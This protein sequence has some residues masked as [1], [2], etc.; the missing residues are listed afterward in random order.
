MCKIQNLITWKTNSD[1][2]SKEFLQ[3]VGLF[4]LSAAS[5]R[6]EQEALLL[7]C[8]RFHLLPPLPPN[9]FLRK[10][11]KNVVM[12]IGAKMNMIVEREIHVKEVKGERMIN[13]M[14]RM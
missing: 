11:I 12:V 4:L 7:F 9:P 6:R 13:E 14:G 8:F 3:S 1:F 2:D 5:D 10:E